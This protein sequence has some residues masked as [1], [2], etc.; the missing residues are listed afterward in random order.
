M[1]MKNLFKTVFVAFLLMASQLL[2]AQTDDIKEQFTFTEFSAIRA[3]GVGHIYL[4]QGNQEKVEVEANHKKLYGR[5][6]M[7]VIDKVL[8]I[9]L[10]N[11]KSNWDNYK[12]V[13]LD[14]YIT[15]KKLNRLV[16]SGATRI[17]AD[18]PIVANQ[19][20][21]K[22][23]GANNSQLNLQVKALN[24]EING[25]AKANLSGKAERFTIQSNGASRLQASE[26]KADDVKIQ[27]NGVSNNYI[28]A[29]KTLELK[30]QGV[31]KI[32]YDG[33]A[34]LISKEVSRMANVN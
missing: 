6:K 19:F 12:D 30:A 7:E 1:I 8:E 31:S 34:R 10:E 11:D 13:R 21:L 15:Y 22:L 2:F 29:E 9:R 16:A 20:E 28:F 3:S 18:K 14:I 25:A 27:S 5:L 4:Q 32:K 24:L 26:L 33:N 23:S 17:Y